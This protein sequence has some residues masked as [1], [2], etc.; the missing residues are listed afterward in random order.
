MHSFA[1]ETG[2]A[3]NA[4]DLLDAMKPRMAVSIALVED[5][6]RDAFLFQERL[7][8][9]TFVSAEVTHYT[10]IEAFLASKDE[11]PDVIVL[12]RFIQRVGLTEGRI[13]QIS[14]RHP[15]TGIIMYT[16]CTSPQLRSSAVQEGAF[17]VVEK[18]SLSLTELELL[19]MTAAC[20]GS[21]ISNHA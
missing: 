9:A 1:R 13:R 6:A 18:G 16:G 19:L 20:V 17:A 10:D 21:K 15:G 4:S 7:R 14:V 5:D 2:S 8:R 12:D 3:L 11:S